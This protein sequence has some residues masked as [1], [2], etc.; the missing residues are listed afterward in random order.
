MESID[1]EM[2]EKARKILDYDSRTLS[3]AP[4]LAVFGRIREASEK[5]QGVRLSEEEVKT[6]ALESVFTRAAFAYAASVCVC[7]SCFKVQVR[8][9]Y[10]ICSLCLEPKPTRKRRRAKK[11]EPTVEAPEAEEVVEEPQADPEVE[12][13]E[14]SDAPF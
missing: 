13:F 4:E 9:P 8:P 3:P 7:T 6:L 1:K 11:I 12:R 2:A 14:E 10:K 5:G